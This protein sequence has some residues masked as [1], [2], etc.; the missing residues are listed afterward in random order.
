MSVIISEGPVPA[1]SALNRRDVETAW[2]SDC[3]QANL[4]DP[5]QSVVDLFEAVLGHHPRWVR[6]LLIARNRVAGLARLDVPPDATIHRFERKPNYA[7]GDTIGPWPIFVLTD[8]ELIAGR[9]NNHL[10]FRFSVLKLKAPSPAVA[11]STIC[12]VHNQFGKLYL[13]FIVP[14]HRWGMRQLMQRAVAA[15]R[16]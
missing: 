16:L 1:E 11:F 3:Y 7:V 4:N 6:L 10:D 14:F 5:S 2:F 12:N 9:N 8:N 13:F 15:G